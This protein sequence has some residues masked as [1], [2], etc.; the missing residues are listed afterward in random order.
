MSDFLSS[1]V[2]QFEYYKL[3]GDKTLVQLE[4]KDLFHQVNSESNSIA[5]IVNHLWGNMLSR[6]TNFLSS[7]GEKEWRKRDLEFEDVIKTREEL[8]NR[9]E[10]GWDCL[11]NA[12]NPLTEED[13]SRIVYIR[14][15][16][17]TVTE[18]INRQMGHYAYHVGQMIFLGKQLK[19]SDWE[20]LSIPKGASKSYN[21][22]K[23]A[24][25]KK[26]SH[27]TDEFLDKKD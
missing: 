19:G 25:E 2:R 15:Q 12:L 20:S 3:L 8:L 18:A 23:F 4:D 16:G 24:Q 11:F 26:R 5:I 1:V 22:D 27:F 10:E 6:W 7:D 9:W 17:H 14:N 21:Q 13:L